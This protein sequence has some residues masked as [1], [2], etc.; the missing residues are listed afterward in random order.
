MGDLPDSWKMGSSISGGFSREVTFQTYSLGPSDDWYRSL[1]KFECKLL[2]KG[3]WT[4][5]GPSR[6]NGVLKHLVVKMIENG[7]ILK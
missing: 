2:N 6:P 7:I 5:W 4:K 3:F 1:S